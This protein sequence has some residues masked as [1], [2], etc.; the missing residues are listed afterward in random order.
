MADRR[1]IVRS[2]SRELD[3]LRRSLVL[4]A[5]RVEVMI[6]QAVRSVMEGDISLAHQVIEEDKA[7]NRD[8]LDI[9]AQCMQ[10]IAR[11]Q[12]VAGD[13]RFITRT[14]KMVTDVERIGDLAVSICDRSVSLSVLPASPISPGIAQMGRQV[15][16][17]VHQVIDAFVEQDAAQARD[18]IALDDDV[19]EL[20][21]H[22]CRQQLQQM[23][24]DPRVLERG[25]LIQ[26]IARHL[27]RIGD[28]C[29]NIAEQV[30]YMV[31][32]CD[33]RHPNSR[34]Q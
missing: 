31:E 26:A 9:D 1:H 3:L 10:M 17:M 25:I 2:Y 33:V 28:H 22:L 11:W 23:D 14:L 30:I 32:G 15:Q 29:T 4:M 5:G 16:A 24:G 34:L 6:G 7:V 13:L 12:P 18:V 27:E 19:D 8:E 21:H 20:Y